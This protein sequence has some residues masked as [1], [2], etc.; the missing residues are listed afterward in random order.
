MRGVTPSETEYITAERIRV[1]AVGRNAIVC[2]RCGQ[3]VYL[4]NDPR[5]S[6]SI[7]RIPTCDECEMSEAV[8]KLHEGDTR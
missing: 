1:G 7:I 4:P 3:V 2:E 5:L 8:A 6:D